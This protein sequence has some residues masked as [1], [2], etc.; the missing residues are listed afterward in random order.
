MKNI[1][2]I[3][4]LLLIFLTISCNKND[5]RAT[6]NGDVIVVSKK[7]GNETVY[8]ISIYAYT[9]STFQSV[10]V[11][12]SDPSKTYNLKANQGYKTNFYYEAPESLFTTSKPKAE[13]YKFNA[14]FENGAT[15][16]FDDVLTDNALELPVISK[17]AYHSGLRV[18]EIEWNLLKNA[19]SYAI[20]IFDGNT[21]VFSTPELVNSVKSY[22]VSAAG[23]GWALGFTPVGGKTYNLKLFAFLYEPGGNAYNVQATSVSE[24]TFDWGY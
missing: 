10:K 12:T 17:A 9:F 2:Q 13:T 1:F 22:K 5:D 6:G 21:L 24:T 20:S 7:S 8:G 14:V 4:A 11:T 19:D 23:G 16:E 3:T 15:D 18:L